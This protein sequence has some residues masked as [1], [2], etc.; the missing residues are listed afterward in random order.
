MLEGYFLEGHNDGPNGDY[1]EPTRSERRRTSLCTA[2]IITDL[3]DQIEWKA[4][5]LQS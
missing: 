5:G 1:C 3:G 2:Y 4:Q